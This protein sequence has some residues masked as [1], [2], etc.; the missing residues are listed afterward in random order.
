MLRRKFQPVRSQLEFRLLSARD[1]KKIHEAALEVMEEVGVRF[2]SNLALD[3][4]EQAGCQVN[5][6]TMVAKLPSKLVVESL[7]QAPSQYLLAGRDPKDDMWIDD[8]TSYLS[9]DGCAVEVYDIE[10]GKLRTST[11]QDITDACKV[12]DYLPEISYVWGPPVSAQDVPAITRPLHEIEASMDGTTMHIQPE[13]VI[14]RKIAE[15]ALEMAAVVAGG[16]EELR[17]RP[18]FSFMQCAMDPLGQDGGSLEASM[19]AAEWGIPT[20]FMP[21][22]MSC[23]TAPATLAGNLV[24]T[25][26]DAVSPLVLMQLVNPGTPVYFAAAPTA[27]DLQTGG[28]TGGGPEDFLLAAAFSEICHFYQIPLAMGAFATGAKEP[29]WQAAVDNSFAG[30]MPVLTRTAILNGAGTLNGSKIFSLQQL[31]MDAEIYSMIA[32]VAEG[33]EV[34]DETL[35]VDVIKKIGPGGNYLSDKHTRRHMKEIWRPTVYDRKPYGAWL[36]SGKKGAFEEA[37]EKARWILKNHEVKPLDPKVKE[38]FARIIK[39]AEKELSK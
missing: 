33:I 2:P 32:K 19:V 29:D 12:A 13:T 6:E 16:K 7:R 8:K 21:M 31:I 25:T 22:P 36:E 3:V 23:A 37:T 17:K 10:T 24:V 18:I 1:I 5:R 35:A 4:L 11:K 28:Y 38:E 15:Y 9:T 26:V 34:N 30:L 14:S 39:A 27:I 20:G